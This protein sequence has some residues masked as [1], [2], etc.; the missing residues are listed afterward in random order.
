MSLKNLSPLDGRYQSST[1]PLQAHFSEWA[2]I[3]YRVHVEIEWL[4]MLAETP[5]IA[6][7]RQFSAD[8]TRFLRQITESFDDESASR[9]KEI[10]R[11]TN[12]DV[13]AV[14]YFLKE[15]LAGTSLETEREWLHF[16]C[17]SEDIN[18]LSH[19]LMLKGGIEEVWLPQAFAVVNRVSDL[20]ETWLEVPMLARTHGQTASPTTVGKEFA[21]FVHRWNRQLSQIQDQEYLGKINGAVGNFNAHLSAYP[22]ANWPQISRDFVL[23]LGLS[24][25]PLTT[26]IESHD[27]IAELFDAMRRFN[28]IAIDFARDIWSYVSLGYFKQK[29][30]AGEVGSSTMP[31]KVNP[32]DFENA[33]ANLGLSNATLEHLSGKLPISRLQRDLTDSSALRNL[34]VG[35][36]YSLLALVA[37]GRGLNKLELN[38]AKLALDLDNAWEVLA[39]PIQTV[40]RKAGMENPYEK[41]K[42]LTRGADMNAATIRAFIEK[43]ELN[44]E[45][46]T[47]LLELTPAKYVGLAARLARETLTEK[48][49]N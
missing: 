37:L 24:H 14:E 2:L 20:S 19:A 47:R 7:V 22:D 40:M 3:K 8:E 1:E 4:L 31:H 12:H 29:V 46:K 6:E 15:K 11:T 38:E 49:D 32:I 39:E 28:T 23:S 26:Q 44:A 13:K 33:E 16:A 35:I 42:E 48:Q 34:G 25:N 43:L 30:I 17:T 27:Y 36:G 9:V 18:N 41:L 21:V 10:E 45:D 5:E